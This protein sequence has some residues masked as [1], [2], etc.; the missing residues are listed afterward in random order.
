MPTN[1]NREAA[2]GEEGDGEEEEEE[3]D[4]ESFAIAAAFRLRRAAS[5]DLK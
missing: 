4:E 1:D 5:S 3:V 2:E